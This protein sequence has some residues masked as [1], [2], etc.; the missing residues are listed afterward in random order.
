MSEKIYPIG[1]QNFEK[2]RNQS[3]ERKIFKIG[4]NFSSKTR[5]IEKWIVES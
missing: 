5:N 4:V 3:D 1:I 2:T